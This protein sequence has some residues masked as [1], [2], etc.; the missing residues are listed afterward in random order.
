MPTVVAR[1]MNSMYISYGSQSPM[2]GS[3]QSALKSWP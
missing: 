2:T 3:T 1:P